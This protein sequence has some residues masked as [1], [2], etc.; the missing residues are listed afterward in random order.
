MDGCNVKRILSL[1]FDFRRGPCS[2]YQFEVEK[3]VF[4]FGTNEQECYL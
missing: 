4:C 1:E 2:T 3:I